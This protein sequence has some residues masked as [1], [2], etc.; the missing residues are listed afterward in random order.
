MS[1][2]P[3][4]THG[5]FFFFLRCSTYSTSVFKFIQALRPE[6]VVG[7][8]NADRPLSL[9]LITLLYTRSILQPPAAQFLEI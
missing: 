9:F 2:S 5:F 4:A 7:Y 3:S 6:T 1:G 8:L